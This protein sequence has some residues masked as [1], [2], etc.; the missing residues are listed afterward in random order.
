MTH[1]EGTHTRRSD[2]YRLR[3]FRVWRVDPL[4]GQGEDVADAPRTEQAMV[5]RDSSNPGML[6]WRVRQMVRVIDRATGYEIPMDGSSDARQAA[7]EL[8][9]YSGKGVPRDDLLWKVRSNL[10][11]VRRTQPATLEVFAA[12]ATEVAEARRV[13][14]EATDVKTVLGLNKINVRLRLL[15]FGLVRRTKGGQWR[16]A[17]P[18][19]GGTKPTGP[20]VLA[21][22]YLEGDLDFLPEADEFTSDRIVKKAETFAKQQACLTRTDS[23]QSL[24]RASLTDLLRAALRQL[25][26]VPYVDELEGY[27]VRIMPQARPAY[28]EIPEGTDVKAAL[29]AEKVEAEIRR[30]LQRG[31]G[32]TKHE[33]IT[34]VTGWRLDPRS[35]VFKTTVSQAFSRAFHEV[36]LTLRKERY[37]IDHAQTTMVALPDGTVAKQVFFR[38]IPGGGNS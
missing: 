21:I 38:P 15:G 2:A 29:D 11:C 1:G 17:G 7:A 31:A 4:Q 13:S 14:Q 26:G 37:V 9:N 24:V 18:A 32:I 33:I 35:P 20:R 19:A 22:R 12:S 27:T 5:L 3:V 30:R 10:Y 6:S 34:A 36:Q 16:N 28:D 8:V 25:D 23:G